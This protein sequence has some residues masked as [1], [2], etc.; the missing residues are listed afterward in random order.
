MGTA[1]GCGGGTA[2]TMA[3]ST[4][5]LSRST[6]SESPPAIAVPPSP[7]D[8]AAENASPSGTDHRSPLVRLWMNT[9]P[10]ATARPMA[11]STPVIACGAAFTPQH[12][13]W[14]PRRRAQVGVSYTPTR[15]ST[16][17]ATSG[18]SVGVGSTLEAMGT[19]PKQPVSRCPQ[20]ATAPSSRRAQEQRCA[21]AIST[22]ARPPGIETAVGRVVLSSGTPASPSSLLPQQTTPPSFRTMHA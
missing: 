13:T 6:Q 8:F 15:S 10:R 9:V 20:Q 5:P 16:A 17:P 3:Q 18:T 4:A 22:A 1:L 21:A 19:S 14:P 12:F 11:S 2:P 7:Y